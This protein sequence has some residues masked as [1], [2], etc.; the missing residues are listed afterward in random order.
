MNGVGVMKL[1]GMLASSKPG[2]HCARRAELVGGLGWV[3][4][5]GQLRPASDLEYRLVVCGAARRANH[6]RCSL[7]RCNCIEPQ[8]SYSKMADAAMDGWL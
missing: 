7:A 1:R 6:V 8:L 4:L 5:D 2:L 3:Q